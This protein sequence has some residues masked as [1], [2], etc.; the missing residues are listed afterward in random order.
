MSRNDLRFVRKLYVIESLQF[1]PKSVNRSSL[2]ESQFTSMNSVFIANILWLAVAATMGRA[3]A[4]P[5]SNRAADHVHRWIWT[6]G[7]IHWIFSAFVWELISIPP[8]I[9]P[10][11][12]TRWSQDVKSLQRSSSEQKIYHCYVR[13]IALFFNQNYEKLT[14]SCH[15]TFVEWTIAQRNSIY[16]LV[17]DCVNFTIAYAIAKCIRQSECVE[18]CR[19]ERVTIGAT[20]RNGMIGGVISLENHK[21]NSAS[22]SITA[23]IHSCRA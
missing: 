18:K 14:H 20:H 2:I 23:S 4:Q 8:G 10:T 16:G 12:R 1:D 22:L 11:L 15:D 9:C 7:K 5:D 21:I 17:V 3:N 19:N 13:N 6:I